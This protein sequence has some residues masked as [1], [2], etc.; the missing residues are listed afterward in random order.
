LKYKK[1]EDKLEE[2]L[3]FIAPRVLD[4]LR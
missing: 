3:I 2:L 1:K 4:W